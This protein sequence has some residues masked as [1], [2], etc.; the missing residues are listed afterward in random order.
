[1]RAV[2]IAAGLSV[3]VMAPAQAETRQVSGFESVVASGRFRVEIAV[4]E[5]YSVT[6]EGADAARIRTRLDG[7]ALRIEPARRPWFGEPRYDALVHVTLPRL[8]GVSAAR[9]AVVNA[10]AGGECSAF[11]AAAAMGADLTVSGLMCRT[12]S[13]SAAMGAELELAGACGT[14]DLSAAM[15]ASIDTTALQCRDLDAS[16]AMGGE[17]EAFASNSY[18][19]SAAMGGDISVRGG[20]TVRDRST[21]MGGSVRSQD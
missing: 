13:A 2:L 11:D 5:G 9:G 12:V 3:T 17:V 8:E 4:G 15:G 6:V 19:A 1:M 10:T 21:A 7:G 20:A 16:A 18:D 14:A